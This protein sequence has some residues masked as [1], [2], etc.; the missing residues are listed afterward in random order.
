MYML[1]THRIYSL[2]SATVLKTCITE[3]E[4]VQEQVLSLQKRPPFRRI[5]KVGLGKTADGSLYVLHVEVKT[6]LLPC[7]PV[8]MYLHFF[9][10]LNQAAAWIYFLCPLQRLVRMQQ[11]AET[12]QDLFSLIIHG[13]QLL[14]ITPVLK[15]LADLRQN[16]GCKTSDKVEEQQLCVK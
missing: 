4:K 16:G 10:W 5:Q 9:G 1:D 3:L 12:V 14:E 6:F 8:D 7:K 15:L 13:L 11:W 2:R